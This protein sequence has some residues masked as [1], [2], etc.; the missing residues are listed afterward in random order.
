MAIIII[1]NLFPVFIPI[2]SQAAI[3]PYYFM[4]S[5]DALLSFTIDTMPYISSGEILVP[6]KVLENLG[7]FAASSNERE[8]LR[9]YRGFKKYVDFSISDGIIRDMDENRMN[10]PSAQIV[11]RR[12]Y[13]PL[14]QI[15]E[16]FNLTY[17]ILEVPRDIIENE[18]MWL[19]RIISSARL[20]GST[21]VSLNKNALRKA[22]NEY[23]TQPP[24]PP[25]PSIGATPTPT[26]VI[27]PPPDFSSVTIHL[28][29]YDL[30]EESVS[31]ILDLLDIQ[32]SLG[33][34]SCFFVKADDIRENPGLIRRISGAGHA[35][36]IL[37]TEGTYEEYLEA[38]ALLF[39]AAKVRTV[40]VT[41]DVSILTDKTI[42]EKNSLILWD[43]SQCIVEYNE[44]TLEEITATIPQERNAR[45]NLLFSCSDKETSILPGIISFLRENK[46]N[47]ERITETVEPVYYTRER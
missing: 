23:Y 15:C 24:T 18:Q 3:S 25:P 44:R 32:A 19:I 22:Y 42:M 8:F 10:W 46:Y 12:F 38:S 11:S 5:N 29:F 43:S 20:N 34:Q 33:Y 37:L 4:A 6:I 39:E 21:F 36:G 40:L 28:S 41:A 47:I 35:I 7:V 16:Y 31:G 13:V 45:R 30:S 1:L 27:E 2:V 9:L 17:E 14:R 26:P